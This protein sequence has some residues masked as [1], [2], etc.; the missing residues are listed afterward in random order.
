MP[1]DNTPMPAAIK[2][3]DETI[4]AL[5]EQVNILNA[6]RYEA[7]E[8]AVAKERARCLAEIDT[9]R[10][11]VA[12]LTAPPEESDFEMAFKATGWSDRLPLTDRHQDTLRGIARALVQARRQ[13]REEMR[14]EA[15]EALSDFAAV[16]NEDDMNPAEIV[17]ALPLEQP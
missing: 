4:A 13:G 1:D 5:Q 7:I 3:R 6:S 2:S 10:E 14:E 11:Q 15:V 9:L 17:I 16:L 12:R 8:A